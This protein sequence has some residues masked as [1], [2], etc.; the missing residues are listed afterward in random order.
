MAAAGQEIEAQLG[1]LARLALWQDPS[2]DADHRVSPERQAG[3]EIRP[4]SCDRRRGERLFAGQPFGERPRLLARA[5]RF[6]DLSGQ[7]CVGPH[8]DLRQERK[9]ARRS[10]P[11]HEA[12][13]RV[14]S[15]A[16]VAPPEGQGH[17]KR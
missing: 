2:A 11:Q 17:L 3:G 13:A 12:E 16:I 5:W 6:V 9:P 4:A 7:D 10:G 1:V 15:G 14:R 8:P